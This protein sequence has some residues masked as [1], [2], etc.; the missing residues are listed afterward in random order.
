MRALKL[1]KSEGVKIYMNEN[2]KF[3]FKIKRRALGRIWQT[4]EEAQ[5]Y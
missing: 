2:F 3:V 1:S 5:G 4:Y